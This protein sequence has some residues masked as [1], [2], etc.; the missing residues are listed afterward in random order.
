M[1]E[2]AAGACNFSQERRAAQAWVKAFH[3]QHMLQKSSLHTAELLIKWFPQAKVVPFVGKFDTPDKKL[4]L[5]E[6]VKISVDLISK[7]QI[8]LPD[9]LNPLVTFGYQGDDWI[10][11]AEALVQDPE[12]TFELNPMVVIVPA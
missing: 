12:F 8:K 5:S 1:E 4:V 2:L 7:Q 9:E 10:K 11:E 3:I 6:G